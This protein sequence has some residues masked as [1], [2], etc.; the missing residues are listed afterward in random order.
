M[1]KFT[2]N[3]NPLKAETSTKTALL[4]SQ[5]MSTVEV[6]NLDRI[7]LEDRGN[8]LRALECCQPQAEETLPVLLDQIAAYQGQIDRSIRTAEAQSTIYAYAIGCRLDVIEAQHLFLEKGYQNLTKF[9]QGGEIR[10]PDGTSITTRQVW[11]YRSVMRGLNDFLNLVERI[12]SGEAL[13]SEVQA[14]MDRIGQQVHQKVA[15]TFLTSYVEGIASVLELGVSKLEQVYR[16]P[17][18]VALSGLLTGQLTLAEAIV[19]I[20]GVSFSELR[21][22]ISNNQPKTK[23]PASGEQSTQLLGQLQQLTEQLAKVQLTSEQKEKLQL[24]VLELKQLL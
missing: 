23:K 6:L 16:L 13:P 15:Q 2:L 4:T 1:S 18:P 9:I 20:H 17:Q 24:L 3:R 12:R 22:A 21:K 7:N 19:P 11:A 5:N 10:R 8:W 14:Q